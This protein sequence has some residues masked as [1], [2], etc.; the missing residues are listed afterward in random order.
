MTV[1]C[2]ILTTGGVSMT[3]ACLILGLVGLCAV[4]CGDDE[5]SGGA[6][7]AGTTTATQTTGTGAGTTKATTAGN[8]TAANTT[9]TVGSTTNTTASGS[10]STGMMFDCTADPNGDA[11]IECAKA[12]CC[13][14]AQTCAAD[15]EC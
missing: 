3:R 13:D 10:T 8:T 15:P 4:G 12:N 14:Q 7:G 11:C 2:E 1:W 6:G 5:G 9:N